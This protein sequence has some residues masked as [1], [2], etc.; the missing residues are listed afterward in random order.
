MSVHLIINRQDSTLDWLNA[1]DLTALQVTVMNKG[2]DNL[3]GDYQVIKPSNLGIDQDSIL[4]YIISKYDCLPDFCIFLPDEVRQ[5][6]DKLLDVGVRVLNENDVV[7][8]MV[9]Q[10]KQYGFSASFFRDLKEKYHPSMLPS[11]DFRLEGA[12]RLELWFDE[13]VQSNADWENFKWAPN[14]MFGVH[15]GFITSRPLEYYKRLKSVFQARQTFDHDYL[16]R[17]WFYVLNLNLVQ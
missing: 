15:K 14:G 16:D 7:Q 13:F 9:N 5:H 4:T 10:T 17:S 11:K 3:H 6:Y 1:V 2:K 8:F 12:Y